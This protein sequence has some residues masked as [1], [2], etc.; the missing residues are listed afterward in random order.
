MVKKRALCGVV[1]V[2]ILWISLTKADDWTPEFISQTHQLNCMPGRKRH[3][4]TFIHGTQ[5]GDFKKLGKVADM[6]VC[7]L[8]CCE[9]DDCEAAFLADR[10]CYAVK[11]RTQEHCVV[12]PARNNKW[13]P[14]VAFVRRIA[15]DMTGTKTATNFTIEHSRASFKQNTVSARKFGNNKVSTKKKFM[16]KNTAT[17]KKTII[18]KNKA[19]SKKTIIDK[20]IAT[21]RKTV[22]LGPVLGG[23]ERIASVPKANTVVKLEEVNKKPKAMITDNIKEARRQRELRKARFSIISAAIATCLMA[24]VL[25]G[26]AVIAAKLRKRREKTEG[27]PEEYSPLALHD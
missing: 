18:D 2:W 6:D 16:D 7:M 1:V 19:N 4:V 8:L 3:D 9:R 20:N 24:C 21:S 5:S 25:S 22:I 17:S 26:M 15:H 10:N 27:H 23:G 11:C 12:A 13:H 14:L